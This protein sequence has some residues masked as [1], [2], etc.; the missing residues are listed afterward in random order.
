MNIK[1]INGAV[2]DVT[3]AGF[4]KTT[5]IAQTLEQV[6]AIEGKRFYVSLIE[7]PTGA[8]DAFFYL[9][10]TGTSDLGLGFVVASSDV[11][12]TEIAASVVTGDASAGTPIEA[13][14]LNLGSTNTLDATILHAPAITGLTDQLTF[15]AL[16][17]TVANTAY[18][19]GAAGELLVPQGKA[20]VMRRL[21][22]TGTIK[23]SLNVGVL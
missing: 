10:N 9:K 6:L 11:D 4:L 17:L 1:G 15:G 18:A 22:A 8:G 5:T 13:I 14:N 20:V 16:Q 7:T 12:T 3:D 21:G 2:A 19:V 23:L